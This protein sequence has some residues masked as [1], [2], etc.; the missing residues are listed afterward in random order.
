[1]TKYTIRKHDGKELTGMAWASLE[2]IVLDSIENEEIFE[3]VP[4][5]VRA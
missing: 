1:M 2:Q 4:E 3:I 5:G